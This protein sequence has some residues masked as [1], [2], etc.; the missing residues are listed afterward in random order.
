MLR[1]FLL[2]ELVCLSHS[3]EYFLLVYRVSTVH[4]TPRNVESLMSCRYSFQLWRCDEPSGHVPV[5]LPG[6]TR[7]RDVKDRG[8]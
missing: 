4:L 8:V 7:V 5:S 6:D 1:T 3:E 2:V